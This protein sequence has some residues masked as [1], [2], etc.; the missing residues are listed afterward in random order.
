MD[1]IAQVATE[2]VIFL[3]VVYVVIIYVMFVGEG[4]VASMFIQTKRSRIQVRNYLLNWQP[5]P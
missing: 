1:P 5:A 3:E 4:T 2:I